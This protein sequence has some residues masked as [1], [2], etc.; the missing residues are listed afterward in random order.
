MLDISLVKCILCCLQ[1][2]LNSYGYQPF[3][4]ALEEDGNAHG[5]LL[6]NSNAMGKKTLD[7]FSQCFF[8]ISVLQQWQDQEPFSH[9]TSSFSRCDIP[10]STCPDIPHHRRNP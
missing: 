1:Y 9:F 7:L 10:A 3:Y 6:L 2:K 4:M 5:V 8:M